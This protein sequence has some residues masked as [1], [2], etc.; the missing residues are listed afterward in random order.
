MVP[1]CQ[2][3]DS[4]LVVDIHHIISI[5]AMVP[6]TRRLANGLNQNQFF[7][8]KKPGL[9]ILHFMHADGG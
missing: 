1:T 2:A 7:T 8:V 5:V 3:I 6:H 9:S 4:I